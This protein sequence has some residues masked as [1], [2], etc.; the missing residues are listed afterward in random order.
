MARQNVLR[1]S[2]DLYASGGGYLPDEDFK[3]ELLERLDYEG[4]RYG[5]PLDN[6]G[7]GTWINRDLFEAAGLDPDTPPANGEELIEMARQLTLDADGNHPGDDG[8]DPNNVA[9]WGNRHQQP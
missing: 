5:V 7:W 4:V 8:F 3:P 2:S 9:Q 1:D 6:L